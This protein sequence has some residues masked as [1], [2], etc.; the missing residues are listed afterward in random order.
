[1][2]G[3]NKLIE[4]IHR[5]RGRNRKKFDPR[6]YVS[7]WLEDDVLQRAG[8]VKKALVIILRTVGCS[9]SRSRS[10][11]SETNTATA[12]GTEISLNRN[13][14]GG[15]NM[16][17]YINDCLP[18][19]SSIQPGVLQHKMSAI[20]A[21]IVGSIPHNRLR[22]DGFAANSRGQGLP[23]WKAQRLLR[24]VWWTTAAWHTGQL[25]VNAQPLAIR[26]G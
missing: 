18:P 11:S 23:G 2:A 22:P 4:E 25:A 8:E 6:Q 20:G 9:W 1:M 5:R 15:C 26:P 12:S 17:G 24:H 14:V 21:T 10:R 13:D 3:L 19:S 16:C 7:A